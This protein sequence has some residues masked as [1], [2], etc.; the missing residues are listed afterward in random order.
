MVF[1]NTYRTVDVDL[2]GVVEAESVVQ[3]SRFLAQVC[4]VEDEAAARAFI[5]AIG[6]RYHDARHHCTA[7]VLGPVGDVR[8]SNDDGEPAG[9]AGRPI[10]DAISGR[11]LSDVVVVVT[12]WFGGTLLGTGGLTRAYADAAGAAL[13]AAGAR[14]RELWQQVLAR[15]AHAEAGALENRLRQLGQMK[16]VNYGAE[17]QFTIA[18]R[19]LA[20]LDRIEFELLS[21]V[22]QDA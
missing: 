14:E 6:A 5:A 15:A 3:R 9:T 8:R 1:M 11:D 17:V 4:R 22:W 12:R 2:G 13:D 7:F 19:D 16:D 20:D 10:L 18:V 21:A